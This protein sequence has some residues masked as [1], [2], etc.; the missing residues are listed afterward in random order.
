MKENRGLQRFL[1]LTYVPHAVDVVVAPAVGQQSCRVE[2]LSPL[3]ASLMQNGNFFF[4][5]TQKLFNLRR[6]KKQQQQKINAKKVKRAG[7]RMNERAKEKVE[8]GRRNAKT[9]HRGDPRKTN[10]VRRIQLN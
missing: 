9:N 2:L 7:K 5:G 3:L 6:N 8:S 1:Q 4:I 10:F